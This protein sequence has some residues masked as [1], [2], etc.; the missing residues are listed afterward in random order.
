MRE[1][2]AEF[3]VIASAELCEA[4]QGFQLLDARKTEKVEVNVKET[5]TTAWMWVP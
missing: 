2:G 1:Q 5:H 4:I 3:A